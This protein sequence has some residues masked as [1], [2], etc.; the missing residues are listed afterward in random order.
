MQ[1][2]SLLQTTALSLAGSVAGCAT[3]APRPDIRMVSGSGILHAATDSVIA[4]GLQAGGEERTYAT[5]VPDEAPDRLG[6][7]ADDGIV[8]TLQNP[9]AQDQCHGIVQLRSTPDDPKE[10]WPVTGDAF[11]WQGRSTIQ[12][13]VDIDSWGADRLDEELRSASELVFTGVWDLRPRPADL[14]D[15]VLQ[16]R[17]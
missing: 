13:E 5:I 10:L 12:A 9:G 14:P 8:D 7:D 2:R 17:E 4:D 16:P 11:S 15:L 3:L 6:P 1:R